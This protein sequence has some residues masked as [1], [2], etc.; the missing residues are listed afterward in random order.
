MQV[1]AGGEIGENFR[2]YHRWYGTGATYA[3]KS[4]VLIQKSAEHSGRV[5]QAKVVTSSVAAWGTVLTI[6]FSYAG[7]LLYAVQNSRLRVVLKLGTG[8]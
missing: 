3:I 4:I 1:Q 2:L 5:T 8:K 6:S 7:M